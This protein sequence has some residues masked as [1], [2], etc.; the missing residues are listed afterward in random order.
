MIDYE[1]GITVYCIL[2]NGELRKYYA[3]IMAYLPI[4]SISHQIKPMDKQQ[5]SHLQIHDDFG[6]TIDETKR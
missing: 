4:Q 2:N 3:T 1:S 6:V 5:I